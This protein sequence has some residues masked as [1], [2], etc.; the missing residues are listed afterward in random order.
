MAVNDFF[1]F[2]KGK[3]KAESQITPP[4]SQITER[5]GPMGGCPAQLAGLDGWEHSL[6]HGGC[7]KA[8]QH[9]GRVSF[10]PSVP[11]CIVVGSAPFSCIGSAGPGMTVPGNRLGCC[12]C[13]AIAPGFKPRKASPMQKAIRRSVGS[14]GFHYKNIRMDVVVWTRRCALALPSPI[15]PRFSDFISTWL[16]PR[17]EEAIADDLI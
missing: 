12:Q 8:Q 14:W 4:F 1:F 2:E 15:L 11:L 10:W 16:W 9:R 13:N 6:A 3:K 5:E 17:R 7:R